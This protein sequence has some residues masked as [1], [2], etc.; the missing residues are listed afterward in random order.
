[1]KEIKISLLI[2]TYIRGNIGFPSVHIRYFYYK[3]LEF[4]SFN[5][6]YHVLISLRFSTNKVFLFIILSVNL[7][8]YDA[9]LG[10][11]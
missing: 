1:M 4:V 11:L 10:T 2:F 3:W 6:F 8:E 7:T 5:A 9:I